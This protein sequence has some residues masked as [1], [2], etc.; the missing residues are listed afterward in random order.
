MGD[1]FSFVTIKEFFTPER[2]KVIFKVGVT[3][4]GGL[5]FFRILAFIVSRFTK[6]RIS[7]QA[8]MIVRKAIFYTG[9]II[10]LMVVLKQ[11]GFTLTALLGAAGVVGI[12]V[13]FAAQ[14]SISN[15][16]SG[17]F[18]I[19]EKPFSVNDA[20]KI[21]ETVG[22][23]LSIDLL[24]TK[25]RS[26]DNLY[27]RIPNEQILNSELTTITRFPIRRMDFDLGVAYKEDLKKV[28][29][30]LLDIA[31]KNT[32]CLNEPEPIFLIKNFG[33]SAVEI[34]F[35]VWFQKDDFLALKNGMMIEI[36]ERFD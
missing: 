4:V 5:F 6:R 36:K 2:L 14:K 12:G 13:G 15:L 33:D 31:E 7:A 27:I 34:L 22:I 26:L 23:V 17:V 11:L 1:I 35:G 32:L 19:S 20:I 8:S 25:I 3:I 21:G 28:R 18:L 16:I 30:I 24:S 9:V 29:A 10:V